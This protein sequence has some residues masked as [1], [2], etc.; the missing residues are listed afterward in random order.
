MF[1]EHERRVR[2]CG[3]ESLTITILANCSSSTVYT[4]LL[5][6]LKELM[7]VNQLTLLSM[8]SLFSR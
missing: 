2:G 5:P 3:Q 1:T 6:E 8:L 4:E 7:Y